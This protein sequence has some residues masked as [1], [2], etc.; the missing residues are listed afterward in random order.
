MNKGYTTDHLKGVFSFPFKDERWVEK[1]LILIGLILFG[2]LLLPYFFVSGYFYEIMRRIIVDREAPSLPEWD[3]WGSYF[4]NG[5]KLFAMSLI[6]SMPAIVL[7]IVSQVIFVFW[8]GLVDSGAAEEFWLPLV[9][10]PI[11][12]IVMGVGMILGFVS[13]LAMVAA[14]GHLVAKDEF[15]AAFRLR[16]I[17]SIFRKNFAG[18]LISFVV[19]MGLYWVVMM[20]S[21]VLMFTVVL[22][23]LYPVAMV[24]SQVYVGVVGSALFA[25]AYVE[26]ADKV[27]ADSTAAADLV[28]AAIEDAKED[29]AEEAPTAR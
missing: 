17:W 23:C 7:M 2:F 3:D 5:L 15:G 8:V 1:L 28:D 26:G 9:G 27:E 24:L 12:Y 20:I 11:F 18:Y 4:T 14:M 25:E 10:M 22:C 16:E 6:Y 13:M 19:L 29:T 21:Q